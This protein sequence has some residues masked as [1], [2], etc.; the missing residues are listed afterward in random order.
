MKIIAK[1]LTFWLVLELIEAKCISYNLT[2][3]QPDILY[4]FKLCTPK[5]PS[6]CNNQ[7]TVK[8]FNQC[9]CEN[10]EGLNHRKRM[11]TRSNLFLECKNITIKTISSSTPSYSHIMSTN[12]PDSTTIDTGGNSFTHSN[13]GPLPTSNPSPREC[14]CSPINQATLGATTDILAVLLILAIIGWVYTCIILKK[15]EQ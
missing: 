12:C 6:Q 7:N 11:L 2:V 9:E 13:R 8:Q 1:L 15:K 3:S 10:G 14:R 4:N 5:H